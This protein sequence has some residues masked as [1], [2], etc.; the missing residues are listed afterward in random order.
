MN[1]PGAIH[2]EIGRT[3]VF[4]AQSCFDFSHFVFGIFL[5]P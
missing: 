5:A 3:D 4:I 1:H 2:A